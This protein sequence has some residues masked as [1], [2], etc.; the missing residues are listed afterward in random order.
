MDV[1]IAMF[2]TDQTV[3]LELRDHR[4]V[5]ITSTSEATDLWLAPGLVDIQVNGF[6]GHDVRHVDSCS[7][8]ACAANAR[9][10]SRP[11]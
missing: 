5:G 3:R 10:A 2:L 9:R 8:S 7:A 11:P 1:G 6:S 4:L